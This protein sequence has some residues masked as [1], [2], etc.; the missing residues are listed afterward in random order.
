M[1][2]TQEKDLSSYADTICKDFGVKGAVIVLLSE[3]GSIY[4]SGHG[5]NH[6]Q[7]NDMLSLGI[8]ANLKQHDLLV[9]AGGAG[10]EAQKD[11]VLI[12]TLNNGRPN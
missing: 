8:H 1:P 6:K 11:A 12:E 7:A 3:N 5:V 2:D 4:F 10:Q 9:L